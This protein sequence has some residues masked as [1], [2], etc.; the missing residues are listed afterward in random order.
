MEYLIVEKTKSEFQKLL[1]QWKHNYNIEIL[2]MSYSE[3]IGRF[4]AL[5]KREVRL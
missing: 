5:I 4:R 1:N 2:W 3:D